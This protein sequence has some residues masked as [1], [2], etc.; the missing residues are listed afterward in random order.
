MSQVDTSA[1]LPQAVLIRFPHF[2]T[3]TGSPVFAGTYYPV[4]VTLASLALPEFAGVQTNSGT[5]LVH[6]GQP[7]L[8]LA[9]ALTNGADLNA[10]ANQWATDW[11]R[12]QLAPV[13][14]VYDGSV[15]WQPEGLS[16]DVEWDA[17]PG[18]VTCHVRRPVWNP[19]TIE[20]GPSL[21]VAGPAG[22][23][24]ASFR[25]G[26]NGTLLPVEPAVNFA[27]SGSVTWSGTNNPGVATNITATAGGSA[28]PDVGLLFSLTQNANGWYQAA[29]YVYDATIPGWTGAT[30][31]WAILPALGFKPDVQYRYAGSLVIANPLGDGKD[32]YMALESSP[33]ASAYVRLARVAAGSFSV[34]SASV[35]QV[36]FNVVGGD[37]ITVASDFMTADPG[38]GPPYN[39]I[40]MTS[41]NRFG[42][43]RGTVRVHGRI[44]WDV[45]AG[46]AGQLI[47]SLPAFYTSES[48][49]STVSDL[50]TL[51]ASGNACQIVSGDYEW[52]DGNGNGASGFTLDAYQTSGVTLGILE[53]SLSATFIWPGR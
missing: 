8:F 3:D 5:E 46:A 33:T 26:V 43:T 38:G 30:V 29:K 1:V 48:P 18:K 14:V 47:T 17:L 37:G 39:G 24:G 13:D 44:I 12:H 20:L 34:S 28:T 4:A 53:A 49:Y 40:L 16:G 45:S 11:Y 50:A 32:L 52:G 10:Y 15:P 35:T 51:K 23:A 2:D 21:S 27:D 7:A 19:R 31:V 42:I 6:V 36:T 25:V 41:G 9:A 22:P